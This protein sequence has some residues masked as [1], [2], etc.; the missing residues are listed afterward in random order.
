MNHRRRDTNGSIINGDSLCNFSYHFG[1]HVVDG[2]SICL[3][4]KRAFT[5]MRTQLD[6]VKGNPT[7]L[8]F[9]RNSLSS[10]SCPAHAHRDNG[11][12]MQ[13]LCRALDGYSAVTRLNL[14][15]CSLGPTAAEIL[16]TQMQNFGVMPN[17]ST[18]IL[19]SNC[20]GAKG[21]IALSELIKSG[22]VEHPASTQFPTYLH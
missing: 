20:I 9:Q 3:E 2:D 12:G 15:H 21:G 17:L 18:L 7:G 11:V 14:E 5:S 10:V 4:G 1:N 16:V 6:N 19:R 8:D 13:A 22:K